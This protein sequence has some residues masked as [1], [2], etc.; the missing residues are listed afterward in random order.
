MN[1]WK[2]LFFIA[3]LH[4]GSFL[5]GQV[6]EEKLPLAQVLTILENRYRCQF[7]YVIETTEGISLRVPPKLMSLQRAV[8]YLGK[9]TGL[10]L[11][12]ISRDIITIEPRSTHLFC[13]NLKDELTKEPI[14]S[15]TIQSDVSAA[16]SDSLGYFEVQTTERKLTIRH[17]GY[18]IKVIDSGFFNIDGCSDIYL[19]QQDEKLSEVVITNLLTKG[20]NKNSDGSYIIN[21]SDF[22]ILPGLLEAD[23]LQ[24]VQ[25]LPGVQ[26]INETVSDINIRGGSN[27]QNLLIWDGIKMY[28]SG[29]FFGLISIYNPFMTPYTRLIKNGSQVDYTD[30]VSGTIEMGTEQDLNNE[31][32]GSIGLN[33]ISAYGFAD[34]PLGK[35]SS[36]QVAARHSISNLVKT[37]TYNSYADRIISDTELQTNLKDQE[38]TDIEFDFNDASLRW[39]WEINDK[40]KLRISFMNVRNEF[41]FKEGFLS[42]SVQN[43]RSSLL[44]QNSLSFGLNYKGNWSNSF[45]T[46]F[47]AYITDYSLEANNLDRTKDQLFMQENHVLETGLKFNGFY[48]MKN[49]LK[50]LTGYQFTQTQITDLDF[51]D[52]PIYRLKVREIVRTHGLYAQLHWE[53][54]LNSAQF[55]IG[56]RFNYIEKLNTYRL[57]PRLSY[58]QKIFKHLSL[59]VLGELKHQVTSQVI[60][61]QT[62]FLGIEKRRWQLANNDD[63]PLIKSKQASVGLHYSKK[64]WLVSGEIY[65]KD[66][67]GITA[68]SQGFQN[69]YEFI[70]SIG[71]YNAYGMDFLIRKE[72]EKFNT[73]LSY[74]NMENH[75]TFAFSERSFPNNLE[76]Y[77]AITFGSSFKWDKLKLSAGFTWHSGKPITRPIEGNEVIN[78]TVNYEPVNSSFLDEYFRTD[79]SAHYQMNLSKRVKADIS[80]AIWNIS[81][82]KNN[83]NTYYFIDDS[84][85]LQEE[86]KYG[87]KTTPNFS[88]RLSF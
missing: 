52:D 64:G 54:Q 37:A 33:F 73:W 51:V 88:F 84:G 23:A 35:R 22:G 11:R 66:V 65:F 68:Q 6:K 86:N 8:K 81:G 5:Q 77:N 9:E 59:E 12:I 19:E 49:R 47:Q 3:L 56:S 17:L 72:W 74:S 46:E 30:G 20:I 50:L 76:I 70:K 25:A 71:S 85:M 7:N 44:F 1:S 24:T 38:G 45:A 32:K 4:V 82:H 14:V 63:I 10:N 61:F 15:A 16:I 40:N 43:S 67:T 41:D 62:D 79:V 27:D 53:S 29:H 87:L 42:D 34:I 2:L 31:F 80:F 13:G 18:K 28:Q 60:N 48:T 75:Y 57:E 69:Q 58:N 55:N 39:L 21:F 78:G 26:S 36:L 83:I